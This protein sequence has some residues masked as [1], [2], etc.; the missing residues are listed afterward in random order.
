MGAPSTPVSCQSLAPFTQAVNPAL[1]V[2][3][4]FPRRVGAQA[5]VCTQDVSLADPGPQ[6]ERPTP[7][8]SHQRFTDPC[9]RWQEERILPPL[10]QNPCPIAVSAERH[11]GDAQVSPV[12]PKTSRGEPPRLRGLP[13]GILLDQKFLWLRPFRLRRAD[14]PLAAA[15]L[16]TTAALVGTDA[17]VGRALSDSPPG[18]GFAFSRRVSKLGGGLSDFGVAGLFYFV[19]RIGK[20]E[21]A[22]RTGV[23]AFRAVADSLV[24]VEA[25]KTAT[26]RPR[27][28]RAGGRLRNHDADGEFFRGGRSFPSGHS[29][30][31]WS[32]ATVV[33]CQ[34]RHRRWVAPVAYSLAA[35]VS[36]ARLTQ[37][38]HFP[39][40]TFVGGVLGYLIGRHVCH[41]NPV[42]SRAVRSHVSPMAAEQLNSN[43]G[44]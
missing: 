24:V 34:Y 18:A 9:C 33:A 27:P 10:S 25:L 30:E 31:A 7:P 20:D 37:R 43:A 2:H 19:G 1:T 23:L 21:R 41:A 17:R 14:L 26:Q 5:S 28:T 36:V 35:L 4:V 29:I 8:D 6:F 3:P 15:F 40:D 16:G 12:D 32:L 44:K 22:R 42:P 38:K 11:T 39:S 13:R